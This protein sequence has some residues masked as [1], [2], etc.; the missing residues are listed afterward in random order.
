ME[1]NA[2]IFVAGHRGMVGSGIV[3]ALKIQGYNN[4]ITRTHQELD[5]CNR[6]QVINFYRAEA[7]EY[8]IL[9]AAKVGGIEANRTYKAEF[10]LENLEIQNNVIYQAYK[11]GVKKLC[12]LGSSCIYP[13]ECP[14]PIKEEYLLDGQLEP[15]NEGYALAKIAGYKL[16][17]YLS[18]QY[19]FN[20]ISLMPCNMYGTNDNYD[21]KG[22]HVF[23]AFIRKFCELVAQGGKE[24]TLWGSGTPRRE[25]LH[26]DDLA[27]AVVMMM[28]NWNS[29]EFV[30]IGSG[31][32]I[33]I[34]ELAEK[35]A[36]ATGF[37]GVINW[38]S[39]MPD[40][41]MRKCMDVSRMKA[42][43]FSPRISL[44]EGIERTI[45]E[46]RHIMNGGS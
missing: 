1:K 25:F 33:S 29:P 24:I 43:G 27:E 14:Q 28:N 46:Y 7:P 44:D 2:K 23:P 19:G 38:D 41:M 21:L 9:A 34:R 20:V 30:N 37:D 31:T 16:G 15:T 6:E 45:R 17:Y 40:G 42:L 22:S 39:S 36:A 32:D 35:V 11:H 5:L 13:R 3:R 10:L 18:Q 12:F 26:V 8:V 4:I